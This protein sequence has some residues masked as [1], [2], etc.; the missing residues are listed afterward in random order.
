M[1][2]FTDNS[3]FQYA[4]IACLSVAL[5]LGQAVKLHMHVQH[6][7]VSSENAIVHDFSA[8]HIVDV[9]VS[10]TMHNTA[11]NDHHQDDFQDHHSNADVDIS[12]D[13]FLKISKVLNIFVFFLLVVSFALFV[14]LLQRIRKIDLSQ[15]SPPTKYYLLHAP[16]RAPPI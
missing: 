12:S 4:L 6:D 3:V 15:T 5:L 8:D 7:G 16:L 9:H 11:H 14:P 13:G 10:S 1:R 2:K